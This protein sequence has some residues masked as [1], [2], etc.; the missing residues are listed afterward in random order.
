MLPVERHLA[1]HSVDDGHG[2]R[3]S[4]EV[5]AWARMSFVTLG[6]TDLFEHSPHSSWGGS[7]THMSPRESFLSI[8]NSHYT[9][10]ENR[11][12]DVSHHVKPL[13]EEDHAA[14]AASP[15]SVWGWYRGV[16]NTPTFKLVVVLVII[17]NTLTCAVEAAFIS[18]DAFGDALE[19]V[20]MGFVLFYVCELILRVRDQGGAQAFCAGRDWQWNT[21]DLVVVSAGVLELVLLVT[22]G[23]EAESLDA[24]RLMRVLRFMRLFRFQERFFSDMDHIIIAASKE[25]VKFAF[26]VFT[27]LFI[28]AIMATNFFW[29]CPD[30]FVARRFSSLGASAW[31]LFQLMTLDGWSEV[32]NKAIEWNPVMLL[33][34]TVFIFL[35]VASLSIVPAIFIEHHQMAREYRAKYKERADLES[36]RGVGKKMVREILGIIFGDADHVQKKDLETEIFDSDLQERLDHKGLFKSSDFRDVQFGLRE[37]LNSRWRWLG[38]D[39]QIPTRLVVEETLRARDEQNVVDIWRAVGST[40]MDVHEMAET[41]RDDY[42]KFRRDV[43]DEMHKLRQLVTG[44][45]KTASSATKQISRGIAAIQ[46]RLGPRTED[47]T[48]TTE[49]QA[50]N[51]E[52]VSCETEHDDQTRSRQ[53]SMD[54]MKCRARAVTFAGTDDGESS[55]DNTPRGSG[56]ILRQDL[57]MRFRASAPRVSWDDV[58]DDESSRESSSRNSTGGAEA[59][60][61]DLCGDTLAGVPSYSVSVIPCRASAA[62][63]ISLF[64][65]TL[66]FQA[67]AL[68]PDADGRSPHRDPNPTTPQSHAEQ[69]SHPLDDVG[70]SPVQ[71]ALDCDIEDAFMLREVDDM[72]KSPVERALDCDIEDVLVLREVE[73]TSKLVPEEAAAP[74]P[75]PFQATAERKEWACELEVRP[76]LAGNAGPLPGLDGPSPWDAFRPFP[77]KNEQL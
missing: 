15:P 69:A 46:E 64:S 18:S 14:P 49:A 19:I 6:F 27:V 7:P 54:S 33:F 75:R 67:D 51:T 2:E 29:Q 59:V 66:A 37:L 20:E 17:L 53:G 74:P 28:C 45:E 39:A 52:P 24:L 5:S 40:R 58:S 63:G 30:D 13:Q 32:A 55:V 38:E 3:R 26:V 25:I 1:R 56:S 36:R 60:E 68:F 35:S 72:S 77:A 73:D 57:Y 50:A 22:R 62:P 12:H 44:N 23:M 9:Q 4:S 34:F 41:I 42:K 47:Q 8:R 76:S 10:L 71:R 61:R 43:F 31:T 65:P 21:F 11:D 70:A 48:S 16:S